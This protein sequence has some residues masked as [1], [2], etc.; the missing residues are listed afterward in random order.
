[1]TK[2]HEFALA[3]TLPVPF[4]EAPSARPISD[5]GGVMARRR[6]PSQT[7]RLSLFLY[8]IRFTFIFIVPVCALVS[9]AV[10]GLPLR[11][12]LKMSREDVVKPRGGRPRLMRRRSRGLFVSDLP[13]V[14]SPHMVSAPA[15]SREDSL[16]TAVFWFLGRVPDEPR[17]SSCRTG[18]EIDSVPYF[19]PSLEHSSYLT[20]SSLPSLV[21]T[22]PLII[23]CFALIQLSGFR[24]QISTRLDLNCLDVS[25]LY[26][27][28][29]VLS[30]LAWILLNGCNI[31]LKM[32]EGFFEM[33]KLR[34]LQYQFFVKNFLVG[35]PTLV[36]VLS[37][38]SKEE[39]ISQLCLPSMNGDALSDSLLSPCFNLLT[40]LLP[41]VAVCTGPEGA[42]E[43]TS[44]FLVD[45]GCSSTSLVTISQLSD[46]VV[47]S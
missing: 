7:L 18:Q 32:Y 34:L 47:A 22:E 36:W 37:S 8:S 4:I 19:H 1:M 15:T 9:H 38:S 30:A 31:I 45:E 41:C 10:N 33:Y 35:S 46:F 2:V 14:L 27:S 39:S 42:I 16:V 17:S 40:G 6:R 44:V 12:S 25:L 5:A 26:S 24:S 43:T 21:R 29:V 13:A 3:K 23:P 20:S 11:L 28:Q